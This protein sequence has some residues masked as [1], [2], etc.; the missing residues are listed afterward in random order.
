MITHNRGTEATIAILGDLHMQPKDQS[1]FQQASEQLA[2][3]VSHPSG[4]VVQLGDLGG[5][6]DGPGSAA[7]FA[8]ANQWLRSLQAPTLLVVGNH[9]LEGEEFAT[10]QDNLRAWQQVRRMRGSTCLW[11]MHA[12]RSL[13]SRITGERGLGQ[14]SASACL[15][16][17]TAATSTG[18]LL[19]TSH[20][21][22]MPV[23][24]CDRCVHSVHEI[25][26]DDEQLAW[27]AQQ[28]EDIDRATPVVVFSHAPPIGCGLKVC[29]CLALLF[30]QRKTPTTFG[31]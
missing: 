30:G 23:N 22:H 15:Q 14:W 29:P 2:A 4:R 8:T 13:G 28:L 5:Y 12:C 27:F 18:L 3:V 1:L 6:Q 19:S 9:D 16:H 10:D 26:I 25:H 31:G 17:A 24:T 7:C 21:I 20:N 11:Y